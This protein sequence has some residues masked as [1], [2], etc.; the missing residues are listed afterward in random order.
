MA[1]YTEN[2]N[3]KKPAGNENV[4]IDDINGNM[5]AID[6]EFG[7][8]Q[9]KYTTIAGTMLATGWN[10]ATKTYSFETEYPN[11]EYDIQIEING[12]TATETQIEAWDAANIKGAYPD[13]V[14]YAAGDI[15][16]TN[17]PIILVSTEK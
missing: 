9:K 12:K 7:N 8:V 2:L 15:P 11:N 13:N 10:S 4:S 16:S 17:I 14:A 1:S 3:L 6:E 5:D